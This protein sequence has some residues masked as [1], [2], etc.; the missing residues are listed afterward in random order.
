VIDYGNAEEMAA[1]LQRL[2]GRALLSTLVLPL[3][4]V[5]CG[6]VPPTPTLTEDA[7]AETTTCSGGESEVD[8]HFR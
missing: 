7:E 2:R 8:T 5:A 6:D 3:T 4:L 1:L